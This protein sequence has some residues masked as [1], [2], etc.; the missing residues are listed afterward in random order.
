MNI[1]FM[2]ICIVENNKN[3]L[4]NETTFCILVV[5]ELRTVSCGSLAYALCRC[6]IERLVGTATSLFS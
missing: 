3:K 1:L 5:A 4:E 6:K 2:Y